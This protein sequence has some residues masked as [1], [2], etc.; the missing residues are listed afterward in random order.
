MT[1]SE[2]WR[3]IAAAVDRIR[4]LAENPERAWEIGDELV[5]LE[6]MGV[7]SILPFQ[8]LDSLVQSLIVPIPHSI[9]AEC[10]EVRR[11][12]PLGINRRTH[13]G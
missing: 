7:P 4:E 5:R 2:A 6:E 13:S 1:E 12:N 8:T 3:K 11:R 9:L 10:V